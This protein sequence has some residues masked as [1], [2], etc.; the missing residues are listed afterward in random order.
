MAEPPLPPLPMFNTEELAVHIRV[1]AD[2]VK[3][4]RYRKTGPEWFRLGHRVFYDASAVE[5]WI[6]QQRQLSRSTTAC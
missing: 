5:A 3:H 6:E 1:P 4:W 2:T